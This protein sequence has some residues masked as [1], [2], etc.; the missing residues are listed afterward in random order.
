[1]DEN[2]QRYLKRV[3]R[4]LVCSRSDR[5]RLLSQAGALLEDFAQENPGAFYKDYVASFGPPEEFAKEMLSNLGPEEVAEAKARRRRAT[6]A[7]AA[8]VVVALALVA[9]FWFGKSA[10]A[11]TVEATPTPTAEATPT[12]EPTETP[13][14][15]P[16]P[17]ESQE[18]GPSEKDCAAYLEGIYDDAED[19]QYQKAVACLYALGV[20]KDDGAANFTPKKHLTRAEAAA[21]IVRMMYG[22]AEPI[23]G[24]KT[25]PSYSDIRGH[26]AETRI[27]YCASAGIFD[28]GDGETFGPDEPITG[29]ELAKLLLCMLGYDADMF[30]LT[31]EDWAINTNAYAN[32]TRAKLYHGVTN[33]APNDLIM[34]EQAAQMFYNSLNATVKKL[35]PHVMTSGGVDF[36]IVDGEK[37]DGTPANFLW[38]RFGLDSLD[39]ITLN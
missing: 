31:G 16:E 5:E 7:A 2:A 1:M 9:G 18:P 34:R 8:A 10:P 13:A 12:P 32:S 37:D 19:I 4:G 20:L 3:K 36:E 25:E 6:F 21:L 24:V 15:S 23:M 39:E 33:M 30:G 38:D 35:I 17:A 29:T 22:G 28:A 14:E 27:E 26:W 11:K